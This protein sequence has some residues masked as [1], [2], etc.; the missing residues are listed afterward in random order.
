MKKIF[1]VRNRKGELYFER[2]LLTE[3]DEFE[4]LFHRIHRADEDP[5]LHN[6]SWWF[7]V[8]ILKG[9][10]VEKRVNGSKMRVAGNTYEMSPDFYHKID[11]VISGPVETV[12]IREKGTED[13]WGYLVDGRHVPY[14]EYREARQNRIT[15]L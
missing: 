15:P 11:K 8:T 14:A 13:T 12:V 2:F 4:V 5:H 3:N 10:Y 9:A 1:E 7:R 6:H